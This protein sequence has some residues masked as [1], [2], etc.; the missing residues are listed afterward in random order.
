MVTAGANAVNGEILG[1]FKL[2]GFGWK[3]CVKNK[4]LSSEMGQIKK[5]D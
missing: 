2:Q 3:P 1:F 5:C 4:A